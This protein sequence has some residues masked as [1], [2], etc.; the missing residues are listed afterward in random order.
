M[1]RDERTDAEASQRVVTAVAAATEKDVGELEPL[2]YS[3][4]PDALNDLF[5]ASRGDLVVEFTYEGMDVTVGPDGAV[6]VTD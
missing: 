5:A 4:D 6:T 3:V 1:S 2:Y